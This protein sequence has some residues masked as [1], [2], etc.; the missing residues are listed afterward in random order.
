[1]LIYSGGGIGASSTCVL[2][3]DVTS[4]TPGSA[5]RTSS[6]LTSTA[7]AS[8]AATADLTVATDR[9]GF[10]ASLSPTSVTLTVGARSPTSGGRHR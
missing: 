7:R 3:V 9:P 1:M 2:R 5:T 8:A 4:A 6:A 10:S